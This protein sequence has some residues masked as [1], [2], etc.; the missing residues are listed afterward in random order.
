[1]SKKRIASKTV[2]V[3]PEVKEMLSRVKA[4]MKKDLEIY[5]DVR[6]TDSLAVRYI[7][8]QYLKGDK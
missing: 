7:A 8:L 4:Q 5:R 3:S 6:I 1:M 2:L